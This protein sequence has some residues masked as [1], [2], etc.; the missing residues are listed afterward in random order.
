MNSVF[1]SSKIGA[2]LSQ[3][4]APVISDKQFGVLKAMCFRGVPVISLAQDQLMT[5]LAIIEFMPVSVLALGRILVLGIRKHHRQS[6]LCIQLSN[7]L[8]GR[9]Q[10][11]FK[12]ALVSSLSIIPFLAFG[13]L[14][15]IIRVQRFQKQ[16]MV[17]ATGSDFSDGQ[18]TFDQVVAVPVFVPVLVEPCQMLVAGT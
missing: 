16:Q 17:N 7:V 10:C 12:Q 6:K 9:I 13:L 5:T 11:K 2:P 4:P 14:W 8:Q 3:E 18:W 15:T 1:G